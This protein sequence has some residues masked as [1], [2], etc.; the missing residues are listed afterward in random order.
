M[1]R[2][3]LPSLQENLPI[4]DFQHG[5]RQLH[6]T[7]T[8]L[9][10]FNIQVSEGF[11]KTRPPDRT[12]LL[13]LDLSKAFDM[14]NLDK[15]LQELNQSTLPPPLKRWFCCYLKGRQAQVHFRN[16]TSRFKNVRTGV[17]QGAVTS[18]VLFNFYL[19]KLP[20]PPTGVYVVQ[21]ADDISIYTSGNNIKEMTEKIN[22]YAKDVAEYLEERKLILSAEK[23]TVTLF[24][25]DTKEYNI[26]PQVIIDNTIVLL[27]ENPNHNRLPSNDPHSSFT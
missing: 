7:V 18:P 10:E 4:P 9:N 21:Y 12:I 2:L 16:S 6:S 3:I 5:F 24:T 14:V 22:S 27:E 19:S 8:A 17:P 20:K 11:S 1:E 25:P 23:S 13:Q 26:H 15:L